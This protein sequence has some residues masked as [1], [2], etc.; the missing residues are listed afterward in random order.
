[1]AKVL[2]SLTGIHFE[3]VSSGN[4][5]SI[6]ISADQID[7]AVQSYHLAGEMIKFMYC[8][9]HEEDRV[10]LEHMARSKLSAQN[11]YP[12]VAYSTRDG[13]LNRYF[14]MSIN[15]L[16]GNLNYPYKP[17]SLFYAYF[18]HKKAQN[19]GFPSL[20]SST[21][22]EFLAALEYMKGNSDLTPFDK[23]LISELYSKK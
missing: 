12:T 5:D 14:G 7:E 2:P 11:G 3:S 20:V 8:S 16:G 21:E 10:C 4:I 23:S 19:I 1:M 13:E 22:S 9:D 6:V 17:V 18:A 15:K